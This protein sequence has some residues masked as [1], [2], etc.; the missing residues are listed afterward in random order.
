MFDT[1][2]V[3]LWDFDGVILDSVNIRDKGYW[4]VLKGYPDDK[5]EK[6]LKFQQINGGLSRFVKFRYFYEDI[7]G[8][9]ISNEKIN[10]FAKQYSDYVVKRLTDPNLLIKDNL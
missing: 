10:H 2:E 8:K 4:N 6:L 3:I 5:V 1:L 7:L 9:D